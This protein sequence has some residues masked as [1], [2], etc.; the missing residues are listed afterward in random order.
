MSSTAAGGSLPQ[1]PHE[2]GAAPDLPST[3]LMNVHTVQFHVWVIVKAGRDGTA[4]LEPDNP[5]LGAAAA[6]GAAPFFVPQTVQTTDDGSFT[7]V[8]KHVHGS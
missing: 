5:W 6:A 1:A 4:G 8:Q 3:G 2:L 7:V